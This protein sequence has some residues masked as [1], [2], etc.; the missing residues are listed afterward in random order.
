MRLSAG[1]RQRIVLARALLADADLL[2]L[3]EATSE[4]DV[5]TEQAMHGALGASR[6]GRTVLIIAHRLSTVSDADRIYVMEAGRVVEEGTHDSLLAA[7]GL[8]SRMVNAQENGRANGLG[9]SK[10]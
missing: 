9:L 2:I 7:G 8:Y 6:R 4:V 3:D 10:T 1:Q 5:F